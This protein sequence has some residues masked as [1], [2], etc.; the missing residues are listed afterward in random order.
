MKNIKTAVERKNEI[1]DVSE[2]LFYTKGYNKTTINDILNEIDIAKG[3][4]Y[5]YFKSKEEV[6]NE[7][8]MRIID[9]DVASSKK[10]AKNKKLNPIEKI[11]NI[12]LAQKPENVENKNKILEQIQKLE[13][14][15][16]HQKSLSLSVIHLSPILA[17]VVR[18]GIEKDIF[19]TEYPQ[20][21]IEYLLISGQTIFDST[22]FQWTPEE[23]AKKM[24]AF[25]Y[26]MEK[27]LGSKEGS[28][29]NMNNILK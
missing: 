5:Y 20:E 2:K 11:Y 14:V 23:V 18:E 8:I 28:F 4:F 17:D 10:I 26:I 25:I 27:L 21:I 24:N 1:L 19:H 16:L 7:I 3:T 12:L 6:M 29:Q 22:L 13:N 9:N 15:E